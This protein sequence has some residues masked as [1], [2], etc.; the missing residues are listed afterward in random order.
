MLCGGAALDFL[1]G[2]I[3][4]GAALWKHSLDHLSPNSGRPEVMTSRGRGWT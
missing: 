2:L 1:G 3:L 4:P